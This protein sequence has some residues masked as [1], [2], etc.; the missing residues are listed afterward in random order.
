MPVLKVKE[1]KNLWEEICRDFEKKKNPIVKN[2][3]VNDFDPT[4]YS[5][6][7]Y[8]YS[9]EKTLLDDENLIKDIDVANSHSACFGYTL[10]PFKAKNTARSNNEQKI[11]RDKCT[12]REFIENFV[13]PTLLPA[14]EKMLHEAKNYKCFERKRTAFNAC[15]FLTTYLYQ[16]NPF[17]SRYETEERKLMSLY[18]IPFAKEWL[19]MHPRPALPKSLVWT[20]EEAALKIQAFFRGYLVRRDPEVQELRQWQKELREEN[21]NII[22]RVEKF[23]ND[24]TSKKSNSVENTTF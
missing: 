16:N 9:Y 23:W 20:E 6:I 1:T 17:V 14:L 10:E 21:Q 4:K 22:Q 18:D 2:E 8:G 11:D 24:E 13:F 3:S 19:Q 12:E 5:P 15:D 7:F